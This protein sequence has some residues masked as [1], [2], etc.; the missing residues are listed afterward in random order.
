MVFLHGKT[1]INDKRERGKV[2]ILQK[3]QMNC[4]NAYYGK[5]GV[6]GDK[7]HLSLSRF[8]FM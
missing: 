6:K 5:V 1:N 2:D 4:C 3:C 7:I 8:S